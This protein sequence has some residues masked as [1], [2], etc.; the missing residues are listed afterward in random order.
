[1]KKFLLS[2]FL[3]STGYYSAICQS[4]D[5]LLAKKGTMH[6]VGVQ[7]NALVRQIFNF[8]GSS[9]AVSNPYLLTYTAL[10]KKSK[11]GFDVGAGYT[12]F[13][14][15]DSDGNTK[16]ESNINELFFRAG[17]QRLIPLNRNFSST[18]NFHVLYD[19]INNKTKSEE[20]FGSQITERTTYNNTVRYGLGPNIGLRYRIS[21]RVFIGTE[22]SYYFKLGNTK[23]DI[24]I[25]TKF[26]GSGFEQKTESNVD[27]DFNELRFNVPAVLYLMV[28]F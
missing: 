2:C 13:N 15:L 12:L 28:R 20:N 25:I 26:P 22:A 9:N 16:R 4:K 17:L 21:P 27:D 10:G 19:L 18:L 14:T 24:T 7:A 5:S 1:M 6:I 8:G 11:W 23:Q 3:V